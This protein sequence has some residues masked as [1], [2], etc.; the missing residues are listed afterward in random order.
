MFLQAIPHAHRR[1]AYILKETLKKELKIQQ[2]PE[3]IVPLDIDETSEWYNKFV[4][5]PRANGKV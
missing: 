4:P 1:V 5:V 2:K 3:I